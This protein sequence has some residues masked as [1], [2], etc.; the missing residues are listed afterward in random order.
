MIT[1]LIIYYYT[2]SKITDWLLLQHTYR[3]ACSVKHWY[4]S[5]FFT[6]FPEHLSIFS[7]P[8]TLDSAKQLIIS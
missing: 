7:A 4:P 1:G 3:G 6:L 2:S 8:D 5:L